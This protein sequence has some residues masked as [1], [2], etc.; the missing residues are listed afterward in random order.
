MG[1]LR[2][3][4]FLTLAALVSLPGR[5]QSGRGQ[6]QPT[7]PAPST[8]N[9]NNNRIP[10]PITIPT[11][12]TAPPEI[13]RPIFLSGRVLT[14]AGVAPSEPVAIRSV[15]FGRVRTEGYTDNKGRFNLEFG[16]TAGV[17]QDASMDSQDVSSQDVS[18]LGR[19]NQTNGNGSTFRNDTFR[20]QN[21]ELQASLP[22]FHSESIL[23]AAHQ[24]MED[25]DVGTILIHQLGKVEGRTVSASN[26]QAPKDARKALEKGLESSRKN[27]PDDAQRQFRKATE[28][29][30]EY[31]SAWAE[32]GK[33][34]LAAGQ[35]GD[36]LD[37]LR[38]AIHADAKFLP[39]YLTLAALQ[40]QFGEWP[41]LAETTSKIVA[42]DAF[43]YPQAHFLRAVAEFNMGHVEAAEQSALKA[44]EL[45]TSKLLPQTWHLLG[46]I[47]ARRGDYAG[48]AD[49]MRAYMQLAPNA[50]ER[51]RAQLAD[52]ENRAAQ[53]VKK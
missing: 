12:P 9:T 7:A 32:L 28:L 23:L 13:E 16:K 27:K 43:D 48:A 51:A 33:A 44:Q 1:S 5:S 11:Q 22:G 21:C 45:D 37:S 15:C 8:G 40:A 31:A 49:R 20:L 46:A 14:D 6:D 18:M 30:P 47:A 3:A 34:Q 10:P 41:D 36:A 29:Y 35:K 52:W 17:F 50:P 2:L 26:L 39:P 19:P 38:K 25:P 42:L 4:A 24:A 53:S